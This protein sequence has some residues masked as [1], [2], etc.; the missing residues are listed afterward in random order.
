MIGL[1][2]ISTE[3]A[4]DS[5]TPLISAETG[6]GAWLCAS[7]NQVWNGNSPALAP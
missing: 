2:R 3:N 7:A 1:I 4:T 6:A 5:S